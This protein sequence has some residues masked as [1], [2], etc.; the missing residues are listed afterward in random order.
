MPS[1]RP[2]LVA[3]RGYAAQYPENTLES[4]EAALK[5]GAQHIEIDVQLTQDEIPVLFH[6]AQLE[7]TS[8]GQ[9]AVFEHSFDQLKT[10]SAGEP[11]RFGDRFT[12]VSIPTLQACVKL[13]ES[14]PQATLFVELK[15]ES[16]RQFGNQRV[17]T[18]V[19][20]VL[21]PISQRC[22]IISYN[23]SVLGDVRL[24]GACPVGWV[25][26]TWNTKSKRLAQRLNPEFLI[27]NHQKIPKEGAALWSGP[28]KW[29][30]Y[31]VTSSEHAHELH[32][33]GVEFVETMQVEEVLQG[34]SKAA[35][36][37]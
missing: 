13:L 2:C 10:L 20:D 9:G 27:V 4:V 23:Q 37:E 24:Q 25:I 19:L 8:N 26:T 16:L 35:C 18:R 14:W 7:R 34:L 11:A 30:V 21:S 12:S 22:V 17:V 15:E 6:D 28:W 31:E 36:T 5:A 32:Q 29:V 3:H 1:T 33:Q